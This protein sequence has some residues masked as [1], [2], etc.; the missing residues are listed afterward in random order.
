MSSLE[1]VVRD[2]SEEE[3]LFNPE[4]S[5]NIIEFYATALR[6]KERVDRL[7]YKRPADEKDIE[8][9]DDYLYRAFQFH[10]FYDVLIANS[11][12]SKHHFDKI[13]LS[14]IRHNLNRVCIRRVGL[15][16]SQLREGAVEISDFDHSKKRFVTEEMD[17][18]LSY[19]TMMLH[20]GNLL[21][22]LRSQ[23]LADAEYVSNSDRELFVKVGGKLESREKVL[24]ATSHANSLPLIDPNR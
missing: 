7:L 14:D 10:R 6:S 13:E 5:L 22:Y 1:W 15:L 8:D 3:I 2:I 19:R 24:Y 20:L 18:I 9:M 17:R 12:L 16:V 4:L 11:H 21:S 23:G